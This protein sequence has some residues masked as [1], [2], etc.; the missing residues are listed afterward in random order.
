MI[1]NQSSY[2]VDLLA[3]IKTDILNLSCK[4]YCFKVVYEID[5]FLWKS[6]KEIS[7]L[8][9]CS[10][11]K[12]RLFF[13]AFETL[14]SF[15]PARLY[16]QSLKCLSTTFSTFLSDSRRRRDLNPRAAINDLH[17][18]QG[19][20]FDHLGTSPNMV[21]YIAIYIIARKS[22]PYLIPVPERREWDSNPRALADKRFSRPPRYDHF[23]IS[24]S[25]FRSSAARI[26]LTKEAADVN[27]FLHNF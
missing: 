9:H 5:A 10:V 22:V 16:Y 13:D 25:V 26:I 6:Y 7:R 3:R 14:V 11:I 1:K 15:A 27:S 20:P 17:P 2:R 18:F 12:D 21:E 19:C 23:D 24:P 4:L 8:F